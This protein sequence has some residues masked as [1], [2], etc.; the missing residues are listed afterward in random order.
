MKSS[1]IAACVALIACG[2]SKPTQVQM[3]PKPVVV[4]TVKDTS[5]AG[6]LTYSGEVRSRYEADLGFRIGGKVIE[7]LVNLGDRVHKGQVLARLDPQDVRLSANAGA[8]QVAA[9]QADL[10]LAKT[11]YERAR[12]LFAQNFVSASAVDTRRS[13]YDAA[14]AR[15]NQVQAQNT[16]SDNQVDYATLKAPRDGVVT[17]LPVEAGQVVAAGQAVVRLADPAQREVLTWIP[18][19][20]VSLLKPGQAALIQVWGAPGKTYNGVLREIAASADTTTRTYAVR[21][22][23][24]DPD[25]HMGLGATATVGFAQPG[26]E[27]SIRIPLSAVVRAPGSQD[28]AVWIVAPDGTTQ[29][30]RVV[31]SA[32]RDNN[33]NVISGLRSGDKVVT[34]GAYALSPGLK[35]KPVEAS[36]PVVLDI[37]R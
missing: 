21:V 16:V 4:V 31:I 6:S 12:N 10:T 5:D 2:C 3:P 7:R 30:R 25:E 20:R 27:G 18:E 13:Q 17:S 33:A 28:A 11:E 32:Y 1:M 8:A 36:A 35:V 22:S 24:S 19:G 15:L 14:L 34:A 29:S 23:V 9:A 37:A 26:V